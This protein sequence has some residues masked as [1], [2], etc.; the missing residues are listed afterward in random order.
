[1]TF[2]IQNGYRLYIVHYIK[3]SILDITLKMKKEYI[4]ISTIFHSMKNVLCILINNSNSFFRFHGNHQTFLFKMADIYRNNPKFLDI[5][6]R[7]I[8]VYPDLI[9]RRTAV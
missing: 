2:F 1:M 7:T 4:M 8:N 5:E 9:A 6:I 3:S